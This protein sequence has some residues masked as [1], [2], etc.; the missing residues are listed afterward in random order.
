MFKDKQQ[1]RQIHVGKVMM[2][3]QIPN[4]KRF[5]FEV[6]KKYTTQHN[7]NFF[8]NGNIDNISKNINF[9]KPNKTQFTLKGNVQNNIYFKTLKVI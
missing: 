9:L 8:P 3:K 7:F 1:Q 2:K 5:E 4:R 6:Q